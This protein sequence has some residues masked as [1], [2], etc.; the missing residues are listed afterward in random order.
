MK[1][2][3]VL[4]AAFAGDLNAL[5]FEFEFF[6]AMGPA[7]DEGELVVGDGGARNAFEH[8]VAD[9]DLDAGVENGEFVAILGS[10]SEAFGGFFAV[11]GEFG[12]VFV[13]EPAEGRGVGFDA[14]AVRGGLGD[15]L[16]DFLGG[17]VEE[18]IVDGGA[19][20]GGEL[21]EG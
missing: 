19:L 2:E 4:S 9:G 14:E 12:P 3:L 5:D 11:G 10:G 15:F 17:E 16:D 13:F 6:L 21:V 8:V 20:V 18:P 1:P 7:A